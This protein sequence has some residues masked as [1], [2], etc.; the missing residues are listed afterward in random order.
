MSRSFRK[1]S[2]LCLLLAVAFACGP[3]TTITPG[4]GPTQT[5]SAVLALDIR[6]S[7]SGE[8]WF[9]G[10]AFAARIVRSISGS[11]EILLIPAGDDPLVFLLRDAS[12]IAWDRYVPM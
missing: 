8:W 10:S 3:R 12:G 9:D 7:F 1:Y 2:I 5:A 11:E 4:T 6:D